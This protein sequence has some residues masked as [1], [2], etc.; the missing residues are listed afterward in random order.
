MNEFEEYL[1]L[2]NIDPFQ[3]FRMAQVRYA[4]VH[5]AIKGYP[6][7][8]ENAQKIT[9]TLFKLTGVPYVGSFNVIELNDEPFR[10]LHIKQL[11]RNQQ[12]L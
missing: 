2:Y 8:P 11:P 10:Q 12:H 7:T 1:L 9:D 5:N 3:L 6:I 4:S